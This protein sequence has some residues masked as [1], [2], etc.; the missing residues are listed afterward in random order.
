MAA[1]LGKVEDG[2][3]LRS[4]C[5]AAVAELRGLLRDGVEPEGCGGAFELAAAYLALAG[6]EAAQDGGVESFT[7]GEVSIRKGDGSARG[8]TMR[9]QAMRVMRPYLRDEGFLFR[10]V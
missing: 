6:M 4:L 2:E 3:A 7:V 10:K 9:R 8:E 1:E 5:R